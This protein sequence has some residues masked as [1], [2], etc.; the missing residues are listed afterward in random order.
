V[1]ATKE[2]FAVADDGVGL[3]NER[4]D[5][6]EYGVSYDEGTGLGLAIVQEIC[7]AHGWR[8]E[9]SDASTGGARFDVRC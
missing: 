9:A 8:V 6:F 2:G 7:E 1:L 4:D 3:P 5:L